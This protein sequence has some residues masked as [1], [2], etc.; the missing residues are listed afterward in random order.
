MSQQATMSRWQRFRQSDLIYYFLK[1]KVAMFC[2]V[3][4]APLS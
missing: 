4:F 1:D 3:I 2:F